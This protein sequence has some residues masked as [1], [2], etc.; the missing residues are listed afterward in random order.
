MTRQEKVTM[1]IEQYNLGLPTRL[2]AD[3]VG[4]TQPTVYRMLAEAQAEGIEIAPRR[5]KAWNDTG[6]PNTRRQKATTEAWQKRRGRGRVGEAMEKMPVLKRELSFLEILH[7]LGLAA[8]I[9][10]LG[11]FIYKE[12]R[13]MYITEKEFALLVKQPTVTLRGMAGRI[14]ATFGSE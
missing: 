10:N 9:D 4:V 3:T 5:P 6:L 11:R 14:N 12:E 1:V 13:K 8:G 2:I 7:R